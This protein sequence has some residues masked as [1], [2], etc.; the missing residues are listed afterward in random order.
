[1]SERK[2]YLV[3][4]VHTGCLSGTLNE[5]ILTEALNKHAAEG[6]CLRTTIRETRKVAL[7]FSREAHFLVF[8]RDA[9]PPALR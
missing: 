6:W 7:I 1:M 9:T 2:T 5:R 8:E 4:P 3:V